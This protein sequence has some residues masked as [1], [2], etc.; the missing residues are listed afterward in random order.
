MSIPVRTTIQITDTTTPGAGTH[1]APPAGQRPRWSWHLRAN[2]VVLAYVALAVLAVTLQDWPALPVPRWL[3]IHLLLLGAATNAIMTWT[4]HFA[5]ALMR[6]RKPSPR[7]SAGRLAAL[8]LSI[9]GVLVGVGFELSAVTVPAAT[10]LGA[11]VL[12]HVGVLL[13]I[14]RHALM[15]R[16]A[17]TVR[18]YVAAG[19]ALVVG[20]SFGTLLAVDVVPHKL[21]EL[22]HA[23]HVHANVFGWVGLT[24]LGTL[25]TLWPTVLRT[26]MVDQVMR[27]ARRCLVLTTTGLALTVTGLSTDLRWVAAAG[28]TTY[29]GGVIVALHPFVAT[30]RR[31]TPRDSAAWSLAAG[32]GWLVIGVAA[33]LVLLVTAP[34]ITSYLPRLDALIPPL[35]V[36]FV[37]QTLLGAL[38]YLLPVIQGGGPA[39]VRAGIEQLSPWWRVRVTTLNAGALLVAVSSTLDVPSVVS[40]LG[41]ALVVAPVVTFLALVI[42]GLVRPSA[43]SPL[44]GVALGLVMTLVPVAIAVSGQGTATVPESLSLPAATGVQEVAVSLV[45]MDIRPGLIEVPAGTALRLVVTNREAM[46]H[47]VA[48]ESGPATPMLAPGASATLDLGTVTTDRSGWCTVPGHRAAGMTLHIRVTGAGGSAGGGPPTMSGKSS[49]PSS[50]LDVHGEPGPGW[51]P[52]DA[53][54]DPAPPSEVH[55]ITLPVVEREA[56]VAPGVRQ[57]TWTFGGMAPGPTLRGKVGDLFEVTLVNGGTTAHG[58]DFHAGQT[59]PAQ[60]MRTLGPGESLV[61]RFRADHAGVWL[62]HCSAMPMTQHIANGMYGAVIIDPPNLPEVDREYIVV[63]SQL[64]LGGTAGG[65]DVGALGRGVEDAA[66]FNGYPD[67]YVHA[68]LTARVGERVRWW[69]VVAGPGGGTA[70]HI[71]GAQFDTVFK[72][73]AYLLRR[74]NAEHGASQVLDLA[75][76]QGGFVEQVFTEPGRYSLVDHDMRRGENGARGIVEVTR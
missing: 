24:V 52:Y 57:T 19:L 12:A 23:A 10:L 54:L 55:R 42:G 43:R 13:Q 16:F 27:S 53:R 41:W 44:A 7:A 61:Y 3:A 9:V 1:P 28:L 15:G 6:A 36:G 58:V 46:R 20:I 66:M 30:W 25:F 65:A 11:V 74:D 21:H 32:T 75:A 69:V 37:L 60:V 48:I 29:G 47:D 14:A 63:A 34:D 4:E 33:D 76:A 2:G 56:E 71:V 68:P 40:A 26:R 31:K 49:D 67:Q 51:T 64:Y 72:E 39:R 45:N 59:A 18:F 50:T 8:N 70:F 62:Y 5:V 73:G 38:T 17:G 22:L 35:A